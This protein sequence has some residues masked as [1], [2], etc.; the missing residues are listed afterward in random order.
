MEQWS[1]TLEYGSADTV[2][3]VA[4]LVSW[5]ALLRPTTLTSLPPKTDISALLRY[6]L[7][8]CPPR[9][10]ATWDELALAVYLNTRLC[11]LPAISPPM[12]HKLA[13]YSAMSLLQGTLV[14]EPHR[15]LGALNTFQ[16]L[17]P[18]ATLHPSKT[19]VGPLL[20]PVVLLSMNT[21]DLWAVLCKGFDFTM[22]PLTAVLFGRLHVKSDHV[23]SGAGLGARRKTQDL[24]LAEH[25]RC[26][27]SRCENRATLHCNM[28]QDE[29]YCSTNCAMLHWY[30]EH[31]SV[32]SGAAIPTKPALEIKETHVI[33]CFYCGT[34]RAS[35]LCA[36]CMKVAYCNET[37][38]LAY[39]KN[40]HRWEC[41]GQNTD[42]FSLPT[43]A[44]SSHGASACLF[45]C[46]YCHT[47]GQPTEKCSACQNTYYCNAECQQA[48]WAH[49]RA[50][51]TSPILPKPQ[52]CT[53]M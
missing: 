14:A 47:R 27:A 37:C 32:C 48:D 42:A 33:H 41:V 34:K 46:N 22:S 51:C 40:R 12:R 21:Q 1:E 18:I 3:P 50:D 53:V 10:H 24:T 17:L 44:I 39:W 15:V 29:E 36:A 28:C 20:A 38:A 5:A 43:V 6:Q 7:R 45:E 19:Y 25:G 26:A 52:F 49:H 2:N 16:R 23:P 4:S 30:E 35:V 9:G 11:N 13:V 8:G 31:R